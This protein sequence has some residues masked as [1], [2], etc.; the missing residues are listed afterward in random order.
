MLSTLPSFFEWLQQ[1]GDPTRPWLILGKGP[2][3]SKRQQY[4]LKGYR[5]MSLNHVVRELTVEA[6]HI[7][8]IDVVPVCAEALMTQARV[9][10]MPWFPHVA[11]KVGQKP[12]TDWVEEIPALKQLAAEGRLCW[13]DL[14]TS[15]IRH[16]PGPV[17]RATY[18]SAE[19]ALSVLALAGVPQV[20]S[21]GVDGGQQYSTSFEDL[22]GVSRLNNGH[23]SFDLQFQ[24]MART[25][26]TTGVDFAPLD[27]PAPVEVF[28]GSE[29]PQR[30]A[31]KV[32]EYSIRRHASL[33][34]RVRPLHRCGIEF[35]M[36]RDAKNA[37]RTPFSFQRFAIPQLCGYHG[38][39]IYLD[40]DMLVFKDTRALWSYP[41][42]GADVL[43]VA[44]PGSSGRKPQFSVMLLDCQKLAHWTPEAIIARL[45]SGELDYAQLMF[46]MAVAREVH[47][48]LPQAWNSLETYRK[49]ETALLHYTDMTRQPWVTHANPNGGL[50][51]S[52]LL[53]AL[54]DGFIKPEEIEADVRAGWVRPS[55]L[56]QLEHQ[57]AKLG[58]RRP[59]GAW[60]DRNFVP[61]YKK[62]LAPAGV[63]S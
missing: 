43:A 36:P 22:N 56:L 3:F 9:L 51:V 12:L 34:V 62:L 31:V 35:P 4:D 29:E 42:Q 2:S 10:V 48:D 33:S 39:G 15:L 16:G 19:A 58:W 20:R 27:M 40:S 53:E 54:Q 18:F 8:D 26:F 7:I 57:C 41:M 6:A 46:Q 28:V 47:S 1:Q 45:D 5:L 13:Y 30:L 25:I 63:P 11:N 49:N 21:L 17:V 61:P 55:L 52:A 60:A 50:W 37:P 24:G 14:S 44:E 38:R 32:L 23:E 59:L